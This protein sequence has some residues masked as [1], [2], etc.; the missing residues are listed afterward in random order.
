MRENIK[1]GI[2][3]AILV[4]I[5]YSTVYKPTVLVNLWVAYVYF[6]HYYLKK[7]FREE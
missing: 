5:L 4:T 1:K 3:I 6:G 2:V 7:L